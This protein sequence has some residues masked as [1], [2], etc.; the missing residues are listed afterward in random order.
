MK[1]KQ[2]NID[3]VTDELLEGFG[4]NLSGHS[5]SDKLDIR[6]TDIDYGV[7]FILRVKLEW[8]SLSAEFIPDNFSAAL[9]KTMG[10]SGISK[11]EVFKLLATK[12]LSTFSD[13]TMEINGDRVNPLEPKKWNENWNRLHIKLSKRHIIHENLA[14][15]EIE[16][17]ILDISG[18]LLGLILS[19]LP[20]EEVTS[21]E[22]TVGLPEG[23]LSH[24]QVNRYERSPFN[25][26]ACLRLHGYICKA[27]CFDFGVKYGNL[28]KDFIHVHHV[29]P[30]SELGPDYDIN[31]ET[32]LIPVCPNC[33]AM[34]HRRN[35]PYSVDELKSIIL[36]NMKIFK[37]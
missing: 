25:R 30:V 16:D 19:L 14:I 10:S 5:Y 15:S 12:C 31:L 26:Q 32:D 33:H 8:R 3:R 24:I 23:A 13:F 6:P 9:L 2:I 27:C 1:M 17:A 35:P 28:G 20:L 7:G 37:S 36:S 29:V 11:K 22:S 4:I 21:E 18:A 34:I